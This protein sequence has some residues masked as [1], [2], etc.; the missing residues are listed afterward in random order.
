GDGEDLHLKEVTHWMPLPEPP[1]EV[2]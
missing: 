2:K 1:Q